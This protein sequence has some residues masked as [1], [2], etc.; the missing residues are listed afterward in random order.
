MRDWR[1]VNHYRFARKLPDYRWAWEFLRRNPEY[2]KDWNAAISRYLSSTGEF[3]KVAD[4][5]AFI[6]GGGALEGTGENWQDDPQDPGFYLPVDE[7]DKWRLRGGLL[8]PDNDDPTHLIFS[9]EFGT[10]QFLRK[11]VPIVSRGP[12]FPI[13][14]FNLHLPLKPQL[15]SIVEPLKRASRH[16]K[17]EPRRSKHHRKLWPLYLRLLDADLDERTPRQIADVL[18][19]ESDGLDERK[20]WDQLRAARRMLQPEGYLSIFLSSPSENS[21]P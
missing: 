16:L 11:G 13:V 8:N 9:L 3:E 20:V 1:D 19:R 21:T 15:E 5:K 10:V 12:T 18:E 14:E 17:I 7:A 6:E 4:L 2:R